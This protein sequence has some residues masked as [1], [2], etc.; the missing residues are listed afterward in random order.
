MLEKAEGRRQTKQK[1]KT[2]HSTTQK[3][4]MMRNTDTT[5]KKPG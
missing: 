1:R 2:Q 4:K 3:I 5:N